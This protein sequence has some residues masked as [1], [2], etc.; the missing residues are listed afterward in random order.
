MHSIDVVLAMLLA[1]AASGYLIRI[2]PFSL[3]LPLVQIALGA[4]VSGVFDAGHE[5]EPELFFLL[6]LPPLLFLDGW[7]IPKQ[8]LF[9]D[10]AAILELALGLVIF[11]VIGA[12]FFIHW[13]I[14]AMP[15]AVAFA[16]AA[17]ISPTD[18]VAVSSIAS[19][20]PI[21]KR[22]MH[23]LEG[24]SLLNDASGLV[25]F[26]FAVAAV[27]TGTFSV[28]AASLTFLWVALAGL[29]LGVATTFGLSR[30]QAWI[31]RHFG[32]EPG[33]AILVNLLTPFAAYLLAEAFHASGILAAVAAGITMSYVEMA[34]NAPGNM[35]L[36]RSAVW[37]TVQFTFNGIIFVLLGEQL[38]G[39]LDGAVR[40][41]QEAGHLN[42]WWLA[43]YVATIS[44]SLMALRFVWVFLSLRWN[45]FKAQR[46]GEAHVSPP[47]RIV[48]A[49]SLAGVRG[50]ITLAGVLTLPLMLEDGSPF[51]ARQLAIFLA[52]SVILVSLL[53]ASVALP[54]L[55]RGLELPEEED[56]QLKEDLAV[57]AASQAALDAVEKLRQRLVEDSKHAERYNAAANQ[58]SQRYQRKLGAVDMAETDPEEAVAYEKALRQFRH[59]ALVAERNELFKLARRREISDDLS[60]RLV[61]NLDLIESRK[62]A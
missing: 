26:Q 52:A 42:P 21:P 37:D 43:V 27:L 8:G 18:P 19:K 6:F 54:R 20:V 45:I 1:V 30:I 29:A 39:I 3:P 7:R 28:A 56:E 59:A 5:L 2:L 24:E 13:L 36:Q 48:V 41:V 51:P 23:I 10:K 38:P 17:I 16:L 49:V 57:K 58:V 60:R 53:V 11:T 34:G 40:S 61:R 46:R 22:L 15:L 32:E 44:L 4:V 25:C 14:P 33:S 62:R 9:R 50:A 55:L 35:R 47:W 12:G 31:W